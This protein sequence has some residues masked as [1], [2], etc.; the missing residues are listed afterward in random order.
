MFFYLS[1]VPGP[2][3]MWMKKANSL[4]RG[5]IFDVFAET[6]KLHFQIQTCGM[7]VLS[8][9][10]FYL[11]GVLNK[12]W[13]KTWKIAFPNPN[14]CVVC[15]VYCQLP[16]SNILWSLLNP[17]LLQSVFEKKQNICAVSFI[18]KNSKCNSKNV[19]VVN[20]QYQNLI[21]MFDSLK[22]ADFTFLALMSTSAIVHKSGKLISRDVFLTVFLLLFPYSDI[23]H[24]WVCLVIAS[25]LLD[26]L[27]TISYFPIWI[28][29][30]IFSHLECITIKHSWPGHASGNVYSSR[31]LSDGDDGLVISWIIKSLFSIVSS[32]P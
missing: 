29:S 8:W 12:I 5:H 21:Q 27:V 9:C 10:I 15:P 16:I 11:Y 22:S 17:H 31:D 26:F 1:Q 30:Q 13:L 24:G 19:S 20:C 25:S 32:S 4:Y 2:H 3:L 28:V 7:F 6:W 14:F 18:L 23:S